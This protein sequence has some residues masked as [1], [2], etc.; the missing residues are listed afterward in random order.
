MAVE[1]DCHPILGDNGIRLSVKFVW[2]LQSVVT[3]FCVTLEFEMH[4]ILVDSRPATAILLW[5][6]LNVTLSKRAV[7]VNP[8]QTHRQSAFAMDIGLQ[9][10]AANVRKL[11]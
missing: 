3:R 8:N 1:F 11:N 5:H 10:N 4:L 7:L 2:Q 9:R 6:Y